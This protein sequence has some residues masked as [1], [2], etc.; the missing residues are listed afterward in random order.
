VEYGCQETPFTSS[1][2]GFPL[3]CGSSTGEIYSIFLHLQ[4]LFSIFWEI[5]GFLPKKE[6][7]PEGAWK[8]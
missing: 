2:E 8:I 1:L 4:P 5:L 6:K 7:A 3:P